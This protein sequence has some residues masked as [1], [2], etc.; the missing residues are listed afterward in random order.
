MSPTKTK[1]VA[2]RLRRQIH[3]G[4]WKPGDRLPTHAELA[5]RFSTSPVTI[6]A[7]VKQLVAERLL[8]TSTSSGTIVRSRE[9][10]DHVVTDFIRADRPASSVSDVFVETVRAAGREPSKEFSMRMEH[11]SAEV[12]RW[13]GIEPES[14]VVVRT[15]RQFVDGQPW[16]WEESWYPKTL[17]EQAGLDAPND[18][19]EG[20]TR[21]MADRGFGELA[22]WDA[23]HARPANPEEAAMLVV[24]TGTWITDYIR[25]G[26]NR[27]Q[28][29]RVTRK[30]TEADQNRVIHELGD[31]QALALIRA[32]LNSGD[33]REEAK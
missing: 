27:T 13:L 30:R 23:N 9:V 25:I 26:A 12:A 33:D 3:D 7:A 21:R 24:P 32:A 4:G 15:L 22:W 20:T 29:T 10:L 17:A 5:K 16:S 8:M 28:I 2:D 1:Y 11:A 6:G 18:I 19:P 31:D 14:W